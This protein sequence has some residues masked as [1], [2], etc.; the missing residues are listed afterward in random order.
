MKK[1]ECTP[2]EPKMD[3]PAKMKQN[4]INQNRYKPNEINQNRYKPK[5]TTEKC[6]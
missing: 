3:G 5:V 4:E 1:I 6:K 2:Y